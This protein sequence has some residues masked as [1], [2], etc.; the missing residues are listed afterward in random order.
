MVCSW[1]RRDTIA[2]RFP[3]G[4]VLV[5]GPSMVPALRHG[6]QV[7]VW[8]GR[9]PAP[10]AGA[11]VLVNLPGERGLGIK[12]LV[13]VEPSGA[14]RLAGDNPAGSTD[15]RQFGPRPPAALR[16]RVV[17]RLWPR[18]GRIPAPP[19]ANGLSAP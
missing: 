8:W 17:L 3:V 6:D 5:E 7:L 14:L 1:L 10:R 11:V 2:V 18:P 9:R 16:G 19:A 15:S 12:R 4:R 13:D